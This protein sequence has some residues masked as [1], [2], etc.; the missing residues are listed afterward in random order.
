MLLRRYSDPIGIGC[1]V[2]AELRGF[3]PL[4][5]AV[6]TCPPVIEALMTIARAARS[7]AGRIRFTGAAQ[8]DYAGV[9]L[10]RVRVR[11]APQSRVYGSS[12]RIP[13][14]DT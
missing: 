2:A 1:A 7:A 3:R 5:A 8:A 13:P 4:A 14:S 9:S 12:G 6:G 10:E 11:E